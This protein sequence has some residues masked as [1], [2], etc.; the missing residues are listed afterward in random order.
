MLTK[1][2][3]YLI[4]VDFHARSTMS[5]ADFGIAKPGDVPTEHDGARTPTQ[6]LRNAKATLVL[7][8][9]QPSFAGVLFLSYRGKTPRRSMRER[10]PARH[11]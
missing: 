9:L 4:P 5:L 11:Y 2:V 6:R 7:F 1:A 3:T 8:P 10:E